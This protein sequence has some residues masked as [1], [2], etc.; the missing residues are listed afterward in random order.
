MKTSAFHYRNWA[1]GTK[2]T[3]LTLMLVGALLIAAI[4]LIGYATSSVLEQ[5]STVQISDETRG[6]INMVDMFDRS[7]SSQV[8]RF[9]NMFAHAFPEKFS[10]DAGRTVQ[11]GD[12]ATPVLR[13][14]S[15]DLNLDFTIPD[16]FTAQTGVTATIFVK[17]GDD[18]V[19]VSTSV[20]KENGERAV[21]TLLD[22]AHPG[23]A[24]LL[25]DKSYTGLATL[26]GKQYITKYVPIKDAGGQLIGILY[27]GVDISDDIKAL[28]D[29]IKALK[30]GQTGYFYVI[31]A[32][33][34][35]DFGTLLSGP[36]SGNKDF[37]ATIA[38]PQDEGKNLLGL[39]NVNGKEFIKEMLEQKEG[40]LHYLWDNP[41][42]AFKGEPKMAAFSFFPKWNWVIVG[43]IYSEEVTA[44][45][46]AIRN[47]LILCG[48]VFLLLVGVAMNLLIKRVVTRPLARACEAASTLAGGDLTVRMPVDRQDEIGQLMGAVNGISDGLAHVVAD[49][50]RGT[51][52]IMTAS[53]EIATGNLDLSSRTEQQA[54][55]LEETAS[56]M[57]ELTTTV[58][59]NADN[60][61]QAN[62][63]ALSASDV[64]SQGGAVVGKVVDTMGSI[65][66]SSRKIVDIISVIDGIAFQTNILAL[67]AA[68]EAARAGEQGRG[69]AVVASEV[70]SL[71]Q[72]SATAAKEIKTLID[73]SV[74]KVEEGSKL[75]EQAGTTMNEVVSSVRRVTDIVGEISSASQEQR[76]GI[77]QIHIAISQME[78]TTQQNAALVEQAAAAAQSLQNQ[79]Q[80]L[81]ASVSTFKLDETHTM[82]FSPAPARP[83]PANKLKI[84]PKIKSKAAPA[85]KLPTA[86]KVLPSP[87]DSDKGGDWEQF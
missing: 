53:S 62:Q 5:R 33:K 11:V 23:Y 72:R 81:T 78:Q 43:E 27:V 13:N 10:L 20:K 76:D 87:T 1:V 47:R 32:Q 65:N 29:R 84:E 48:A 42:T 46:A 63:L 60:A 67:N 6:V 28:K 18:F 3:S 57:E 50:R 34:G 9:S 71:A 2:L 79:A 54:G 83:A 39:K 73:D 17:S 66:E 4:L 36:G 12:K 82:A 26:F 45:I 8:E 15:T 22:R 56:A 64:A 14:G 85:A 30:I 19:R 38:G 24:A 49:V 40:V 77:E 58:K 59:Q 7:I 51:E 80:T 44:E 25:A 61:G 52:Q 70:R 69:F 75:V 41:N 55:S 35:K 21:G 86:K 74:N 68:V 37:G 31:N 16:R